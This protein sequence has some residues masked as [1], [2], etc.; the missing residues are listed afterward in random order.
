MNITQAKELY[1]TA[2]NILNE[3]NQTE[4]E[5]I[6]RTVVVAIEMNN[7]EVIV[8]GDVAINDQV[9]KRLE[10]VGYTVRKM[11]EG[12]DDDGCG[13]SYAVSGWAD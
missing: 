13:V 2:Q 7:V 1:K 4:Y 10:S 6:I 8:W 11:Y 12:H 3:Q 5:N 9:I